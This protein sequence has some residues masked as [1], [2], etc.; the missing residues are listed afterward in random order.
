MSTTGNINHYE[1]LHSEPPL[2]LHHL[3]LEV[4]NGVWFGYTSG[5]VNDEYGYL[6][7]ITPSYIT[8]G[9]VKYEFE[10]KGERVERELE[11]YQPFVIL[12]QG[13][14]Y[15][16]A[17]ETYRGLDESG[18]LLGTL[19]SYNTKEN[20]N[21]YEFKTPT[22]R[23]TTFIDKSQIVVFEH[24]WKNNKNDFVPHYISCREGEY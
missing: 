20:P 10:D 24:K 9:R 15:K 8:D 19:R 3:P 23:K 2:E 4:L 14:M 6:K 21:C 5:S 12:Y 1:S 16:F 11:K 18:T 7:K 17:L 22:T 13:R